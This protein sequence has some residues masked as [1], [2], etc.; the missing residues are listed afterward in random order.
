[1]MKKNGIR[2]NALQLFLVVC[3]CKPLFGQTVINGFTQKSYDNVSN[4]YNFTYWDDNHKTNVAA[5]SFTNHTSGYNLKIDYNNLSINSLKVNLNPS[6]ASNAFQEANS[7]TFPSLQTGNIDCKILQNGAVL[8][9][10]TA[11]PTNLGI[12][13][14][15][16]VEYGTWLNRRVL[17]SLNFTNAPA[18]YGSYSGIEVSNW[19]NR[20]KITFHVKPRTTINNAQL[21]LA[22][23]MPNAYT[24]T[25]TTGNIYGFATSATGDGFAV[26]AGSTASTWNRVGNLVNVRTAAMNLVANT[27]YEISLIFYVVKNN[28]STVYTS[29]ADDAANVTVT[30]SQTLP[31][32][33]S[34]P[35]TYAA[36][37]GLYY[38]DVP[39]YYMG[40]S[41]CNLADALQNLKLSLLNTQNTDKRVRLCFRQIPGPNI[42]GFSSMLRNP[43]GDPAGIPLQ[44]SKN[45]HDSYNMLY[46]GT[47]IR[48]YTEVIVPSN[49]TLNFDYTRV[50]A[51]WGKVYGAF[52]HQLSVVGAGVSRGGWL[53]AGLGSFGEN[54]T[55]SPDY[56]YGNSNICDYRPFLVTNRNYGGTST[57]CFWTGNTG[58]MD[59]FFYNNSSGTRLYQSQVKTRFK[60]YGPNLTET[61]ISAYSA[62]NKL[63]LDYTFQLHR[64]D[65]YVR[66]Y[67]K[68]KIK[69]LANTPFSRFDIFQLGSDSYNYRKAQ[70][71]VYGNDAGVLGQFTPS[72]LGTNNYSTAEIALSGTNPWIWSGDGKFMEAPGGLSTET[73]NAIIIRSYAALLG[74]QVSNTPY[75]RE[76]SNGSPQTLKPTQYCLVPPP[77]VTSFLQGDSIELLLESVCLPKQT[78]DYYGPNVNFNRA[79]TR[80]GNTWELLYREAFGNRIQATS[81]T[82][83]IQTKYPLTVSTINNTG[84]VAVTG[85]K[86]YVPIVFKGLSNINNPQLWSTRN[87]IWTLVDQSNYGKD[88]WQTEY[89]AETGL[90]ELIYNVNQDITNDSIATIKYYLGANP[91]AISS[92]MTA[93]AQSLKAYPNPVSDF[94]IIESGEKEVF[95]ILNILGQSVQQGVATTQIDVSALP[96]GTYILQVGKEQVKFVKQ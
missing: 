45:W 84:L 18:L 61:A 1:M 94:L 24:Q 57:E 39:A 8:H 3:A 20:F 65:D 50:G 66:V 64:S 78:S 56:E 28:F 96:Q 6:T 10:K 53:E 5:R 63:K 67:Y 29:A 21:E 60:K 27:P 41:S 4:T 17:D 32:A 38:I 89:D 74:G 71:L 68:I 34:V 43:N 40:Y 15:Q 16:M 44:I 33:R 79:L 88:F 30:T 95:Q 47:W 62:D 22:V 49:S 54:I 52:S 37:E 48:E 42:V 77:N 35:V 9:Q 2:L 23:Q 83:P 14:G 86:G 31:T 91:P 93:S 12:R 7:T 92:V 73:N 85:G 13:I 46:S 26:K 51:K 87:N 59:L 76:R 19:H 80:Y 55:H 36:D 11:T 81:Q 75:F 69:A 72:N 90:F 82:N 25:Y 58:G 70:A